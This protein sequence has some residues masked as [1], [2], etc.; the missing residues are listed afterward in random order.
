[1]N[2]NLN[3]DADNLKKKEQRIKE[4]EFALEKLNSLKNP[5]GASI[6]ELRKLY[7]K[8]NPDEIEWRIQ[9]CGEKPD[10]EVWARLIPYIDARAV[11]HRLDSCVGPHRWTDSYK[12]IEGGFICSL[13]IYTQNGWIT[14]EDAS[15]K[16]Q[17]EPIKGGISGALKRAATK[18]G[19][20]RDLYSLEPVWATTTLK[21]T[22]NWK[23]AKTRSGKEFWWTQEEV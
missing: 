15:D 14:K 7:A 11:M 4:L 10:G 3:Q 12:E 5:D 13:S 22:K 2:Q 19:I 16:S 17:I 21:K 1:M 6:E 18:W 20:G 9:D 23:Y 8:T